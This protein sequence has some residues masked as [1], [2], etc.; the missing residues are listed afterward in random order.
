MASCRVVYRLSIK[1]ITDSQFKHKAPT[2][3]VYAIPLARAYGFFIFKY[4]VAREIS[5][6][7]RLRRRRFEDNEIVQ[8]QQEEGAIE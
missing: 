5:R 6:G 4:R 7:T 2:A 8:I 3:L 1:S